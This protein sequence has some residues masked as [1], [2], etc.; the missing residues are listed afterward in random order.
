[1]STYKHLETLMLHYSAEVWQDSSEHLHNNVSLNVLLASDRSAAFLSYISSCFNTGP[2]LK[3]KRKGLQVHKIHYT[4]SIAVP[5]KSFFI[6]LLA[7]QIQAK[8]VPLKSTNSRKTYQQ[9]E[10]RLLNNPA[11]KETQAGCSSVL[12]LHTS[13]KDDAWLSW[14]AA[15]TE[16]RPYR[17]YLHSANAILCP[18]RCRW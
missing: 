5:V 15:L 11:V 8:Y 18:S 10:N 3:N 2:R 6:P 4:V 12:W 13:T 1:M 9:H 17:K 7:L 16:H 14:W